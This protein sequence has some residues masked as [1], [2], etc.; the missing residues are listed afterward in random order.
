MLKL[1]FFVV[2]L[3][4]FSALY[5]QHIQYEING[6]VDRLTK[7]KK[8]TLE[9]EGQK[10]TAIIQ[11]DGSFL[12]KGKT[13]KPKEVQ[14]KTDSSY[15]AFIWLDK[16]VTTVKMAEEKRGKYLQLFIKDLTGSEDSYL[17]Y[18]RQVVSIAINN[19]SNRNTTREQFDSIVKKYSSALIDSIFLTRPTS[20]VL[21][22]L[23]SFYKSR[24]GPVLAQEYYYRLSPEQQ[25]SIDGQSLG[26][27]LMQDFTLQPGTLFE[28]FSMPDSKGKTID[29][30]TIQSKY[31][32][33]DF[34]ASWCGPCRV[35]HPTIK[36]AFVRYKDKG[37]AII[38]LSLDTEKEEW[39][40]AIQKDGM[41]WIN[42]SD[43][44]GYDGIV[45]Q[46]TK[47]SFVPFSVLLDENRKVIAINLKGEELLYELD[48]L[49][50]K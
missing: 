1:I 49:F 15:S 37:L 23:I 39:L 25:V 4:H 46:K 14:I 26:E 17:Y 7:S 31:I 22:H 19:L 35:N 48:K 40:K 38:S 2:N 16:G 45:A 28:N 29:L 44:Q 21:P 50:N 10:K 27:R 5:S 24:L 6:T 11:K 33:I 20:N 34:W 43:L 9:I 36:E 30:Y 13:D 3:L 47:L 42:V 41:P 12:L 18:Y 8:I 32:L